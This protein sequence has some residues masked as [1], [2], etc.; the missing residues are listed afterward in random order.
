MTNETTGFLS[1]F[2]AR[3]VVLAAGFSILFMGGGRLAIFGLVFKPMSEDLDLSRSTLSAVVTVS[4]IASAPSLLLTGRLLDR[5]RLRLIM[6]VATLIS[7]LSMA[8]MGLVQ[9]PWQVFL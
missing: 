9:A 3:W 5:Y 7:G 4:T 8:A 2:E 1:R 6:L